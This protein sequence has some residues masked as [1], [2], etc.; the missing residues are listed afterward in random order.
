[1]GRHQRNPLP[2]NQYLPLLLLVTFLIPGT[3]HCWKPCRMWSS[4]KRSGRSKWPISFEVFLA[5]YKHSLSEPRAFCLNQIVA[6]GCFRRILF[7]ILFIR[8]CNS[9]SVTSD[10]QRPGKWQRRHGTIISSRRGV[11]ECWARIWWPRFRS[12]LCQESLLDDSEPITHSQHNL[13]HRV[14][15]EDKME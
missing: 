5:A 10:F 11:A 1:M 4:T 2:T 12:P 13:S 15:W 3:L 14:V 9:S 7:L 8:K 6:S